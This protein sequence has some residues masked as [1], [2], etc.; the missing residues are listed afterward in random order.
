[1]LRG[2]E[3]ALISRILR[4]NDVFFGKMLE[5]REVT[6][7]WLSYI[8]HSFPHYTRHTIPHSD[9]IIHQ[10]S[11]LLFKEDESEEYSTRLSPV[12]AYILVTSAYLHDVGMVVSD[13]EKARILDSPD[14]Q[15]W[16]SGEGGGGKR[17][18]EVQRFRSSSQPADQ[19]VRNFLAD[20]EVRFLVAEFI[21]RSHQR[22]AVDVLTQ[23]QA[24]FAR[25]AFD[26][27][28]LLRTIADVCFAHGLRPYELQDPERYPQRRDV[29]G[30]P[31]NVRFLAVLLRL[32][33]LLDMSSDR[34]CPLLLNAACPLPADSLAH[35]T[36]HQRITH[37]LTAPDRIELTAECD[38]QEEHR[39]LRDWAQWLLEEIQNA[40][41]LM[42]RAERHG[43]WSPPAVSID[44]PAP[45]ILIRPSQRARY[46]PS[47]WIFELDRDAVFQR[48]IYSVHEGREMFIRELLQ[49]AFD[50]NRCQ[51]FADLIQEGINLPQ[52]PTDVDD[53]DARDIRSR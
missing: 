25:F 39:F 28:I 35:W 22:R 34:A 29:L 12:E 16:V 21:R 30:E 40:G 19:N 13:S 48:L 38:T 50:A 14:W 1:M 52:Y 32:G 15:T 11:K 18:E 10:I 47:D 24:A 36:E 4:R 49:N 37:R 44:G 9:E 33:D 26:D 2:D 8:P 42:S 23:H 31:A 3:P 41:I 7:D 51:M 45:T 27:P 5:L 46:I 17:W 20:R 53:L 43:G 6:A